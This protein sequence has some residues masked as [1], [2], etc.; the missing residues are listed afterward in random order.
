MQ[1]ILDP[2]GNPENQG[3]SGCKGWIQIIQKIQES[4]NFLDVGGIQK[5]QEIQDFLD[6]G[7]DP[8]NPYFLDAGGNPENPEN[9]GFSGCREGSRKS[10]IFWMQGVDPDNPE[11][12]G[13]PGFSGCRGDPENPETP[14]FSGCRGGSRKSRISWMP[15][16]IQK[17]QEI[18][19]FLDAGG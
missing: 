5:I 18:Q 13:K 2:V 7:G 15:W 6:V 11:N 14:R 4:Q 8:E 12:S 3:F 19:D 16:G 10:R 1:E 17:I 9:P